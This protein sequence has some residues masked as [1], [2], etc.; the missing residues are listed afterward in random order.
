ME[1]IVFEGVQGMDTFQAKSVIRMKLAARGFYDVEFSEVKYKGGRVTQPQMNHV[2][3]Y[4][5]DKNEVVR[6]PVFKGRDW[7]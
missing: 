1:T 2:V 4:V 6:C 3:L 7:L 5:D